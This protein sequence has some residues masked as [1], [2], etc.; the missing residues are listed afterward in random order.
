MPTGRR[1]AIVA[2]L[3]V[4]AVLLTGSIAFVA[5]MLLDPRASLGAIIPAPVAGDKIPVFSFSIHGK[6]DQ[7]LSKPLSVVEGSNGDIYV[8]DSG[9]GVVQV[10]DY[11]GNFKTTIGRQSLNTPRPGELRYPIGVAVDEN[12]RLYV[13]DSV[14]THI[15]IFEDGKFVEYMGE[16]DGKKQFSVPAGLVYKHGY[17]YVNDIG[18]HQVLVYR[19]S[20]ELV[21]TVGLGRGTEPGEM[22]FPNFSAVDN[23]GTIF[24]SDSNNNRVQIFNANGSRAGV[25]QTAGKGG[26]YLPRGIGV[27]VAGRLHVVSTFGHRVEVF[28]RSGNWLFSYGKQGEKD[29]EFNFPNGLYVTAKRIYVADRE[30]NRVQVWQY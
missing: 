6:E 19:P 17:L 15:S 1:G 14:G 23:D 25:I 18:Y 27:D 29:G 7:P 11:Q 26:V 30:N 4:V 24:V 21:R 22:E 3:A 28:D 5:S 20:G 12:N 8:A 13:S 10:F 16:K 2:S 9:N